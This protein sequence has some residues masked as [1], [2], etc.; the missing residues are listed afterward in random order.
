MP[1]PKDFAILTFSRRLFPRAVAVGLCALM[2]FQAVP[3]AAMSTAT[4]IAQGTQENA[5]I[6]AQSVV[7]HDPFLTSWVDRIGSSLAAH[8]QRKDITY[9]F[10]IIDDQS[11][12]AFSI[13]GEIGRASCR[14]SV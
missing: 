11:I 6:D 4:E 5:A 12:N 2:L 7:V 13:K 1:R 8:R 14:E 3:A 10:T 9:R